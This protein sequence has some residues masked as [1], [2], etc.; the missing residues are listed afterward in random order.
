MKIRLTKI[1]NIF[2][3]AFRRILTTGRQ[4][5]TIMLIPHSEKRVFNFRISIFTIIFVTTVFFSMLG[6]FII[7]GAQY[8]GIS[9]VLETNTRNLEYSEASL[10]M[11]RDE[12]SELK[13]V[14]ALHESGIEDALKNLNV[15]LSNDNKSDNLGGDL[16]A[17]YGVEQKQEGID[18]EINEL[19]KVQT[20]L[21]NSVD[22]F[23]YLSDKFQSLKSLLVE[24]P[25]IWPVEK[26]TI[27]SYWGPMIHPVYGTFYLHK[28]ID[29]T[30]RRG[31]PVQATA[32]G[33]VVEAGMD[34]TGYFGYYILI[35][36]NFGFFTKYAHLDQ[37]YVKEGD[38]VTQ[39]QKIGAMGDTGFSTGVHVH[40]EIRI[41]SQVIDPIAFMDVKKN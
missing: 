15:Q 12:I 8:S 14:S 24:L 28:G 36:H 19:E 25:T 37:L 32:S 18:Y 30:N 21:R 35:S 3:K 26:G 22:M 40:Y 17:L 5:V 23:E 11:I 1:A 31:Y 9:Q 20:T 41:G 16:V 7:Y 6:F 27:S 4:K 33:R 2:K 39:G 13:R 38:V 29:I 10:E 34:E